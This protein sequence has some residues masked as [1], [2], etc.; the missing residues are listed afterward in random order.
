MNS[1]TSLLFLPLSSVSSLC[2]QVGNPTYSCSPKYQT[3]NG[4]FNMSSFSLSITS[5]FSSFWISLY[6]AR[7][8]HW[9]Q[10]NPGLPYWLNL[11]NFIETIVLTS[12]SESSIWRG[13]GGDIK[14]HTW[15]GLSQRPHTYIVL[16]LNLHHS[17][18][19]LL[20]T[21]AYFLPLCQYLC[22]CSSLFSVF[23][24]ILAFL[25]SSF[26]F[27]SLHPF[28]STKVFWTSCQRH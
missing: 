4:G 3:P 23:S 17:D 20:A 25:T 10:R 28:F 13:T 16:G 14:Y 5:T 9:N 22:C 1:T 24:V 12:L 26:L 27:F 18:K 7:H 2:T 15:W 19:A 11:S 6:W 21:S 8:L